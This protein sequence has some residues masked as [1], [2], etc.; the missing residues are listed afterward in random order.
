MLGLDPKLYHR[1]GICPRQEPD[2]QW[3]FVVRANAPV[4]ALALAHGAA[5]SLV[6][7]ESFTRSV[8]ALP[9]QTAAQAMQG[10]ALNHDISSLLKESAALS[11]FEQGLDSDAPIIRAVNAMIGEAIAR[12]ASDIHFEPYEKTTVVRLRIDGVLSD[13]V[14]P[15][16][17][18]YSALISR[19]KVM[20]QLDIAEKR[21]PQDGRISAALGSQTVD[22]RVATLPTSHGERVVL[23]LLRKSTEPIGLRELGMSE[24]ALV[25]F[26]EILAKPNGIVLVTG[27]TG[28]GKTTTLYAA[29]HLLK[30]SHENI[31][32]V[33]DPVEYEIAGVSQTAVQPKIGLTFA[34]T[35]RAILRQDPDILMVGEI[36]DFETAQIAVQAALTGH[37]VLATMHTNDAPS[38]ITRLVDMGIEPFLLS[39][40]LRAVLAQRLIRKLCTRCREDRVQTSCP[41]CGGNGYSGRTGIFELMRCDSDLQEA[42]RR[43]SDAAL[44]RDLARR[45]GMVSLMDDAARWVSQGITTA[46]EVARVASAEGL[47]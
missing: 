7:D 23:R 18:V 27:P 44:L 12:G 45:K 3:H 13:L 14:S 39:S 29:I 43:G 34:S 38:A 5:W 28:S 35:L 10:V 47:E 33:E 25:E 37:L 24:K 31:M 16:R 6:S 22:L 36:R 11:Q 26:N 42:M 2:G 15:P 17:E 9:R 40:A 30:T 4:W 1:L 32:T 8:E 41:S 20:A 21:L 46:Q 19:V